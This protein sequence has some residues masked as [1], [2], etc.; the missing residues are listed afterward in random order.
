[1]VVPEMCLFIL[2]YVFK[3]LHQTATSLYVTHAILRVSEDKFHNI[4][5]MSFSFENETP[6]S[7]SIFYCMG[8]I[9]Q[10]FSMQLHWPPR[11]GSR[12]H[13][14]Y[15]EIWTTISGQ[16]INP[17]PNLQLNRMGFIVT[18]STNKSM[19]EDRN[20]LKAYKVPY[21]IILC[22]KWGKNV[23]ETF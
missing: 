1:M 7:S 22:L 17:G 6:V 13:C 11:N 5:V 4:N 20:A 3:H 2:V 21:Y 15:W 9:H 8:F 23:I 14:T 19:V 12:H 10:T 18:N 16:R